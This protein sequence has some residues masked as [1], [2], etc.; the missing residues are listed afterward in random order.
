MNKFSYLVVKIDWE[1]ISTQESFLDAAGQE[2]WELV[3]VSRGRA[4][5][6]RPTNEN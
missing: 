5:F 4:Y 1:S 3:T 2:G 6:K